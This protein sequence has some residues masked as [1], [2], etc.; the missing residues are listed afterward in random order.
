MPTGSHGWYGRIGTGAVTRP[1]RSSRSYASRCGAGDLSTV[2]RAYQHSEGRND[3]VYCVQR[4]L[5]AAS[6]ESAGRE[7]LYVL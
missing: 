7:G 4:S 1:T 6:I 2:P 5:C 3:R